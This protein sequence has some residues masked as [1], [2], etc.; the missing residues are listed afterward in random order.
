M[1]ADEIRKTWPKPWWENS[2]DDD[3][4][5]IYTALDVLV[6]IAAQLAEISRKLER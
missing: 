5:V 4:T 1:T 6:E 3:Q 2:E